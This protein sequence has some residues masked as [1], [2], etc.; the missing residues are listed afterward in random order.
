[1]A[2]WCK[3]RYRVVKENVEVRLEDDETVVNVEYWP[4]TS[5]F[6]VLILETKDEP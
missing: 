1:M 2:K 4:E 6:T 5:S 3:V